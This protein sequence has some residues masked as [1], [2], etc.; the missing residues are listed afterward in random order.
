VV[1]SLPPALG[2]RVGLDTRDQLRRAALRERPALGVE[3]PRHPGQRI[4]QEPVG[5]YPHARRQPV[6]P[7]AGRSQN[8][9]SPPTAEHPSQQRATAATGGSE[10]GAA[11]LDANRDEKGEDTVASGRK[12]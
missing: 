9:S 5:H 7:S 1:D 2:V 8:P 4:G 3:A 12:L 6:T 11:A 10:H